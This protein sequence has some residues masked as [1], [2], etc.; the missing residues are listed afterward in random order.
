MG[1]V[2][3]WTPFEKKRVNAKLVAL[4]NNSNHLKKCVGTYNHRK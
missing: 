2:K 4:Y 3:V 1:M